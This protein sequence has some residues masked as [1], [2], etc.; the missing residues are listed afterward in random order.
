MS[1]VTPFG[2]TDRARVRPGQPAPDSI[3][4]ISHNSMVEAVRAGEAR[5]LSQTMDQFAY[6]ESTWW[7]RD[8]EGWFKITHPGLLE[9]LDTAVET[10]A[11][12]DAA[13]RQ[14]GHVRGS[15]NPGEDT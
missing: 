10:M 7:M 1:D 2:R 3:A 14:D 9:G 12:A 13:V 8:Q 5:F 6:Y 4:E 11:A 15:S